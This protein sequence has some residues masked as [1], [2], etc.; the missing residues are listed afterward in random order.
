MSITNV[1]PTYMRNMKHQCITLM[2]AMLKERLKNGHGPN[3]VLFLIVSI[4]H[5]ERSLT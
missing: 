5:L 2:N 3:N 1:L 4:K